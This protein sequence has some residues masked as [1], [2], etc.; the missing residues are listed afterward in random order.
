[1]CVEGE[2]GCG[3]DFA[4]TMTPLF[5]LEQY[6]LPIVCDVLHRVCYSAIVAKL[7]PPAQ[8]GA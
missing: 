8:Q 2:A 6:P 5:R 7:F 3:G 1:M 4:W